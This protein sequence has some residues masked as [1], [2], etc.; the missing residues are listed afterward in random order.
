MKITNSTL[1]SISNIL[2][3]FSSK[4]LPQKISYAITRNIMIISKEY[5][6][7]KKQLDK[8]FNEYSDY[9]TKDEKGNI[10]TDDAG[11]PIVDESVNEE[12]RSQIFDLLAI[13]ID[14]DLFTIGSR[15][16]F[17]YDD[18]GVYDALSAKDIINLQSLLCNSDESSDSESS[19]NSNGEHKGK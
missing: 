14:I 7:Y 3:C 10:Q 17:D 11:I 2:D 8:L 16:I 13:E 18:R 4:K 19:N 6:I 1:I 9:M 5:E 12:F 15:E